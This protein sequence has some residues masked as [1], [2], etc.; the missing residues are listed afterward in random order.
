METKKVY[1]IILFLFLICIL[2]NNCSDKGTNPEI[3]RMRIYARLYNSFYSIDNQVYSS[4]DISVLYYPTVSQASFNLDSLNIYEYN[5]SYGTT[6]SDWWYY[7]YFNLNY[8]HVKFHW[9]SNKFYELEITANNREYISTGSCELPGEFEIYENSIP[10][11]INPLDDF[12]L[13]WSDCE[14]ETCFRLSYRIYGSAI[15][16]SLFILDSNTNT[17]TFT[18]NMLNIP[19]ANHIFISLS[20]IN[21]PPM[22][23]NSNGN[24]FGDGVGYFY[25]QYYPP[26]FIWISYKETENIIHNKISKIKEYKEKEEELFKK[27]LGF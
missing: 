23:P 12:E 1:R 21:G 2:F 10:D 20:A 4:G 27:Y 14:N 19:D 24:F 16:D 22:V 9:I 6:E 3:K 5:N 18:S 8:D 26:S 13:K 11:T 15:V 7:G 17:F 25:G